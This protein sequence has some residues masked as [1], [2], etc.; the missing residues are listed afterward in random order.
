MIIDQ[1][2]ADIMKKGSGIQIIV[3]II[4]LIIGIGVGLALNNVLI[5][6]LA[7]VTAIAVIISSFL[8]I[9]KQDHRAIM[10]D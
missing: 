10:L 8:I 3:G 6:Y 5:T 7:T 1:S 4:I 9:I 2:L